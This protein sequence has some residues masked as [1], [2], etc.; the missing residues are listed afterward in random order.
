MK[1]SNRTRIGLIGALLLGPFGAQ[2]VASQEID[3]PFLESNSHV[4]RLEASRWLGHIGQQPSFETLRGRPLLIQFF[5]TWDEECEQV[6]PFLTRLQ[7]KLS[8]NGLVVL[9]LTNESHD[10]VAPYLVKHPLPFPVGCGSTTLTSFKRSVG[11]GELPYTYI[12]D[13]NGSFVWHGPTAQLTMDSLRVA[14]RGAPHPPSVPMLA[15]A[16]EVECPPSLEPAREALRDGRLAGAMDIIDAV[17]LDDDTNKTETRMAGRLRG[18]IVVHLMRIEE[19]IEK[20]ISDGEVLP[21][22]KALGKLSNEFQGH[23]LGINSRQRLKEIKADPALTRELKAA[24]A[25]ERIQRQEDAAIRREGYHRLEED[26]DGTRAAE[27]AG[28]LLG[29]S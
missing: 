18:E 28:I 23:S 25:L 26:F 17:E 8:N 7:S 27:K 6:W 24:L 9:A 11:Q 12:V 5:S 15:L 29:G 20:H 10:R 4:P 19:Q 16:S 13:A 21:A 2:F 3:R 14:L 22:V 1:L